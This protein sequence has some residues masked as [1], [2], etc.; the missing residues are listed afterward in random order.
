MNLQPY[1][2]EFFKT[3]S[4][5]PDDLWKACFQVPGEGGWWYEALE[6]SGIDDQFT[7]FY[8]LIKHLGCPVGI[9]PVFVMDVPVEQVAPQQFLGLLRLAGKIVPSVLCQR[10]LFVGSPVVEE[11][12]VGLTS[13]VNRRAALLS[14][15]VA[16]EKKANELRAPLIVW[17][18]FPES[19]SAD[20]NWLS[21]QRRFFRVISL[22]NM[23]VESP[24]HRKEGSRRHNLKKAETR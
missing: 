5:I 14:L 9:A 7:F 12:I 11:S 6:Q 3:A 2:V 17:K 23:V 15:Q 1:E 13:D 20:L 4:Q 8:G 18:D 10:T 21:H 19:S 24:S 16:L 22:P